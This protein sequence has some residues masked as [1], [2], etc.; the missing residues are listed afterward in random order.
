MNFLNQNQSRVLKSQQN[1]T[2]REDVSLAFVSRRIIT[3]LATIT[4]PKW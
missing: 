3:E 4:V 2:R 1:E